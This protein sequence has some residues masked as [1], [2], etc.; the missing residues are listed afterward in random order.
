MHRSIPAFNA[1]VGAMQKQLE[2]VAFLLRIPQRKPWGNMA[3]DVAGSLKMLENR[4][5]G[6]DMY[7]VGMNVGSAFLWMFKT[8]LVSAAIYSAD[9]AVR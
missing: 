5:V 3:A 6:D 9:H 4:S 7:S 2:D 1:D 8:G